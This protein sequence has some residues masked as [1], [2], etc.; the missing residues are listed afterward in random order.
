MIVIEKS[1]FCNLTVFIGNWICIVLVNKV[2]SCR[3]WL[4]ASRGDYFQKDQV[5][6]C[7]NIVLYC[8]VFFDNFPYINLHYSGTM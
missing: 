1:N 4:V 3:V 5:E 6:E 2:T 8:V 7:V